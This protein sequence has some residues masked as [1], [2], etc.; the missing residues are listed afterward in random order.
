MKKYILV[1][2]MASLVLFTGCVTPANPSGQIAVAGA[3]INPV[4]V[5]QA[6]EIAAQLG[7]FAVVKKNPEA[8]A[9]F[10]MSSVAIAA[11]ISSGNYT[12]ANLTAAINNIDSSNQ[13][14]NLGIA[15]AVS[16]YQAMY[17]QMVN[18]KITNASPYTLPALNGLVKGINEGLAMSPNTQIITPAVT[19]APIVAPSTT[20][21]NQ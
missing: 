17:G 3:N 21:T 14:V 15:A 7:T 19:I 11:V 2:L 12:P 4:A 20:V 9:Y 5:S 8:R 13:E 6:I 18:E 10:A 16:L 1:T